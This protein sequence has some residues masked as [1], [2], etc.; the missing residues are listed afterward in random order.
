MTVRH[1][2]KAANELSCQVKSGSS[3]GLKGGTPS[4]KLCHA[5]DA[6][7][8]AQQS[9]GAQT[10]HVT[11][12]AACCS[13]DESWRCQAMSFY[14]E[15]IGISDT[16][17][18]IRLQVSPIL[19]ESMGKTLGRSHAHASITWNFMTDVQQQPGTFSRSA[20]ILASR[21]GQAAKVMSCKVTIERG[22]GGG[23]AN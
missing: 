6:S 20:L 14:I 16:A 4:M 8:I 23:G 11:S 5:S 3:A 13:L 22:G 18:W 17:K 10:L 21:S 2:C 19:H 12:N 7:S 15:P 9:H 1:P